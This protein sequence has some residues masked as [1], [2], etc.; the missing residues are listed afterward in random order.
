MLLPGVDE[1]GSQ[2]VLKK[3]KDSLGSEE[4]VYRGNII[5][6][7]VAIAIITKREEELHLQQMLQEGDVELLRVK[8][9]TLALS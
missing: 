2:I 5:K 3:I 6:V 1:I 4:Y 9:A 8:T 7:Q